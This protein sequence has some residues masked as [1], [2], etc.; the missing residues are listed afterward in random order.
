MATQAR[1]AA[2]AAWGQ[3]QP[4]RPRVASPATLRAVLLPFQ[5]L[6]GTLWEERPKQSQGA[7][8]KVA[9]SLGVW[10]PQELAKAQTRLSLRASGR[11]SPA[12]PAP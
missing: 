3:G 6:Q 9:P 7:A 1:W 8:R 4:P 12:R 10:A 5:L 11:N 2:P